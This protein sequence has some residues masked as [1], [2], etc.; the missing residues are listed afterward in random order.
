MKEHDN[1]M[2]EC[3]HHAA[4]NACRAATVSGVRAIR[5]FTVRTVLPENLAALEELAVNLRWSWDP[6][7]RDLFSAIDAD[8]WESGGHDPVRLLGEVSAERLA[9]LSTAASSSGSTGRRT[10]CTST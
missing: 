6:R 1:Y 2:P 3:A 5:R 4:P 7:T 9:E 10:T 8:L